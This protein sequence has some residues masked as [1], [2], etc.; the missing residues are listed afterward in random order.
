MI[1]FFDLKPDSTVKALPSAQIMHDSRGLRTFRFQL[2]IA[3]TYMQSV[4][5][6]H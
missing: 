1:G 2:P 5:L 4:A 3:G 6:N